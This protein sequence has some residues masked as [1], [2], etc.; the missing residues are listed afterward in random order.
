MSIYKRK[1]FNRGGRVSSRGVGITSGLVDKPVQKFNLGGDVAQKYEDNL[2]MLRGLDIV[3]KREAIQKDKKLYTIGPNI[4]LVDETG[5]TIAEGLD[6][7][8]NQLY[9]LDP[10]ERL[11]NK[12]GEV[13]AFFPDVNDQVIKL[14]PGQVAYSA[15]GTTVLAENK[16]KEPTVIK[17]N[18]GQ[19]AY[20]GSGQIIATKTTV[21]SFK[22]WR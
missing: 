18:P 4:K 14:N 16:T 12:A 7:T 3:P 2:A 8:E 19:V 9:K 5:A 22:S 17:L 13:V 11:V 1:L 20:D 6:K 15:D 10:G 21:Q